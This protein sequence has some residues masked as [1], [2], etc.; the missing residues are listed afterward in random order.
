MD[1]VRAKFKAPSCS[2]QDTL[3]NDMSQHQKRSKKK[4]NLIHLYTVHV[5]S[6]IDYNFLMG[7][8]QGI[9]LRQ[10]LI[11]KKF[12]IQIYHKKRYSIRP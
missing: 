5:I 4:F 9:V 8:N 12:C 3:S 1:E 2:Q 6:C 7:Q 11:S 10:I